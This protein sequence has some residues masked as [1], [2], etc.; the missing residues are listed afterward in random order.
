MQKIN[1][2]SLITRTVS[3]AIKCRKISQICIS[4][5]IEK[6]INFSDKK[7]FIL[8]RPENLC[9]DNSS[10][11][12]AIKHCIKFFKYEKDKEF[13]NIILLQPT[14]PFRRSLDIEN[15]IKKFEI[16]KADS[17]FSGIKTKQ[18]VWKKGKNFF[19][20]S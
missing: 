16:D 8:K 5:N 20:K 3:Q 19:S 12:D 9:R 13:E 7:V 14:S 10:S 18:F 2:K 17:L 15:A 11:E 4:T 6:G 1:R